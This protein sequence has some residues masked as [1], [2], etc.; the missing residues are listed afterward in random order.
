M[1][2]SLTTQIARALTPFQSSTPLNRPLKRIS[3]CGVRASAR[4]FR[5]ICFGVVCLELLGK[6]K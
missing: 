5:I 6:A 1:S 4:G 3:S 2:S